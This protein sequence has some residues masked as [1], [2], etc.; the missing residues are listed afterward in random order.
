[1]DHIASL[2]LE[3]QPRRKEE[4]MYVFGLY[5]GWAHSLSLWDL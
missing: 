3:R 5:C 1:M 2:S 4:R